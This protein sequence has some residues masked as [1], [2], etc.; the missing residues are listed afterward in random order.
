MLFERIDV[1]QRD[2][3]Y[4][5]EGY[6]YPMR[7]EVLEK[8]LALRNAQRE[9][10]EKLDVEV[11]SPHRPSREELEEE[12]DDL[13]SQLDE[14]AAANLE[15]RHRLLT[16]RDHA[17]G[18][19]AEAAQWQLRYH[20]TAAEL[21]ETR[22][23]LEDQLAEARD[24]AAELLQHTSYRLRFTHLAGWQECRRSV[25]TAA[26][27]AS[28]RPLFSV[29]TPVYEPPLEVLREAIQSVLDQTFTDWELILVDDHSPSDD[30]REVL[31]GA[32]ATDR[33]IRVIERAVNG[34]IVAASNDAL[35]A[36]SGIFYALL[37]HDDLLAPTALEVMAEVIAEYPDVDY[38]YSDEDKLDP[39]GKHFDLFSKPDWSP[40][41]QRHQNYTCHL[42]VLRSSVVRAVGGFH[43]GFDGSQDHDLVLRVSERAR[44]FV[45][46]PRS[47]T[48]GVNYPARARVQ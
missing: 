30:V 33:R 32:K 16:S 20:R 4:R 6:A 9:L 13:Q 40:E 42:S 39:K 17:I 8:R 45:H 43:N 26:S 25:L 41:R 29:V 5:Y 46:L 34:G 48:T 22:D 38:L 7:V 23:R 31:R 44:P 14:V 2:L 19:E 1:T 15:L 35:A 12:K 10:K 3:V 24:Q 36:G 28:M 27:Q 47:S 11:P 18:A 37:D 21:D